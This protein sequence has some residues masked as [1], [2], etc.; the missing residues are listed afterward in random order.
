MSASRPCTS[1]SPGRSCTSRRPSR[2]ASAHEIHAHQ[3]VAGGRGVALV[4]DE[5]DDGGHRLEPLAQE[6]GHRHLVGDAGVADLR[7][8]PDQALGQRRRRHQ[9]RARDLLGGQSAQRAQGKAD[10]R[11]HGQRRVAAGEDEAQAIVLEHRGV[12]HRQLGRLER[13]VALLVGLQRRPAPRA[14]RCGRGRRGG[15]GSCRPPCCARC[16]SATRA[17]SPARPR[18]ATDRARPRTP[19]AARPRRDRSR[20]GRG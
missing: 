15:G 9:E 13:S 17:G 3:G 14:R 12:G 4:E 6:L 8:G 19:P 16:W 10:L 2:I 11:L 5:I 7:L 1:A 18:A 20:P